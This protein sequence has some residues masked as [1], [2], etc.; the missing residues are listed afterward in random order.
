MVREI[1]HAARRRRIATEL[2]VIAFQAEKDDEQPILSSSLRRDG[3]HFGGLLAYFGGL[4]TTTS[5]LP[6]DCD[7]TYSQA[8]F[9][10]ERL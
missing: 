9:L 6:S 4:I 5:H 7:I 2:A 1:C 8:G 3:Y 10:P